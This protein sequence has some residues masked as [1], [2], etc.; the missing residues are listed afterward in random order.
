MRRRHFIQSA[1]LLLGA[2]TLG[3]TSAAPESAS[4]RIGIG[5]IGTGV[6]GKQLIAFLNDLHGFDIVACCDALPFRLAEGIESAVGAPR[7]YL[8]H[9]ELLEDTDVDAVIIATPFSHHEIAALDALGAGKHVYC[10]KTMTMGVEGT[11]RVLRAF[12]DSDLIFQTGFQYHTSPL[13]RAAIEMIN[14]G[15]IGD[16]AAVRCQWN[17]NGNWRR[18]VPDPSLERQINWRMYR[19]YSGGL[20]A[21]L[22]AHQMDFCNQVLTGG[23]ETISGVGGIDYWSDGRETYDNI[24]LIC[25]YRDGATATFTSL[26]TNS[27]GGYR[28]SVFGKKGTIELTTRRGWFYPERTAEAIPEGVDLVSGATVDSVKRMA[29]TKNSYP[30]DASE[31]DPTPDALQCFGNAIRDNRQPPSNVETGAVVSTMVQMA[32][33]AMDQRTVVPYSGD[34]VL[35][36]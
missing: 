4:D 16:V 1:G 9:R 8:D 15:K 28:I 5:I 32:L 21:E 13:Y 31:N 6:R 33:D 34:Y 18:P 24:H 19:E 2:T 17:R 12:R 7:G 3:R 30:I 36:S 26:T 29:D 10:E 14:G 35:P 25:R 11:H 20:A 22:S 23:I 27:L